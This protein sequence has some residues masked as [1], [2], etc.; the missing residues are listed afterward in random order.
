MGTWDDGILDNDSASDGL[1]DLAHGVVTDIEGLGAGKTTLA[2]TSRLG[3]AVGVLLQLSPYQFSGERGAVVT[4]AVQA[5]AASILRFPPPFRRVLQA[6]AAGEGEALAERRAKLPARQLKLL[7]AEATA[8]PFGKREPALFAGD[9]AQAYVQQVARRCVKMVDDDFADESNWSDLCR[10]ASGLGGLAALLVLAP[11]KVS[12]LKLAGW[13]RKARRGLA[14]LEAD[15]DE[16]LPFQR[17]YHAKLDR[18]FTA[19]L[20]RFAA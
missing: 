2:A 4:S 13:Q 16:E 10:E 9:S 11:C 12:P 18:V 17:K 7:H 1:L 5:H 3:G 20:A 8:S 14:T 15:A 6:V 19:L